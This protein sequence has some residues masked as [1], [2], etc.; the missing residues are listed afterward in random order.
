MTK[1]HGSCPPLGA[2]FLMVAGAALMSACSQAPAGSGARPATIQQ[3]NNSQRMDDVIA[4]LNEGDVKAATKMLRQMAKSDPADRA[5]ARLLES[6]SA[7]PKIFL[8]AKSFAYRVQPGDRLIDLSRR[9]LGDRLQFFA[10]A[11]YNEIEVPVSLKAGQ[12]IRIP[13]DEPPKVAPTPRPAPPSPRPPEVAKPA[14][15]PP[16]APKAPAA[17]PAKAARLRASGLAALNQGQVARAVVLLHQ[18]SAAAPA[19]PLIKRDLERAQRIRRTVKS[20]R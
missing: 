16:P 9:F 2:A 11:R 5:T 6:L 8:G 12:L 20:K 13:G 3:I 18:A 4:L 19:D 14:S 7:D 1:N 15:L 17:D 10:L